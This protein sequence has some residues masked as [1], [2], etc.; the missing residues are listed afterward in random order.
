[1]IETALTLAAGIYAGLYLAKKGASFDQACT[2]VRRSARWIR[3]K[4]FPKGESHG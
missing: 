1:M 2:P 4:L 3:K